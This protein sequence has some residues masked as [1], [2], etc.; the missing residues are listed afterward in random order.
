[1]LV[2]YTKFEIKNKI[3]CTMDNCFLTFIIKKT[4]KMC[5]L[6]DS[7]SSLEWFVTNH[8]P[9]IRIMIVNNFPNPVFKKVKMKNIG[10]I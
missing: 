6:K 5:M 8:V 7:E 9:L 3:Y 4:K 1:M 2:K 10:S